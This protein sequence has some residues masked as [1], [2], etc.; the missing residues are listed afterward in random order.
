MGAYGREK[1]IRLRDNVELRVLRAK[2]NILLTLRR[3][4]IERISSQQN[5]R[6]QY[7]AHKTPVS[8]TQSQFET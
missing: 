1:N 4:S 5:R 8:I 7:H 2:R 6:R 3:G